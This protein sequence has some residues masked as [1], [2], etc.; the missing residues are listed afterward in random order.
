VLYRKTLRDTIV[1]FQNYS[2]SE[3]LDSLID[4]VGVDGIVRH[5]KEYCHV[6]DYNSLFFIENF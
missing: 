2:G 4:M 6:M 3:A 5:L 1:N